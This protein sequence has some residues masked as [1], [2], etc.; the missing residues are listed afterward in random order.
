MRAQVLLALLGVAGLAAGAPPAAAADAATYA[1]PF[2]Y[3][4]A[5]GTIDAPD[6]RYSGPAMPDVL[7]EELKQASGAPA[8]A[9]LAPFRDGAHWRCMDGAVYA[10]AV[11]ANLPCMTKADPGQEPSEA[12]REFCRAQ[13]DAPAIPMVVTGRATIHAWRCARGAP[14]IDGPPRP[15][16]QAGFLADIWY[17]L[18]R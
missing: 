7:A 4:A 13:P 3:C 12:M 15:I 16:D 18:D 1:D 14:E 2:D 17:R 10:C 5:I 9:P 6:D 11:G 8:D